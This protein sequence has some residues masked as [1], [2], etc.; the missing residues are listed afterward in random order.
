M[1]LGLAKHLQLVTIQVDRLKAARGASAC[2]V[3]EDCYEKAHF[4]A[5]FDARITFSQST[6]I[7]LL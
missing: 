1:S 4:K 5:M 6:A 2:A 7:V 3:R